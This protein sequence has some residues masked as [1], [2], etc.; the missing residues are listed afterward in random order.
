VKPRVTTGSTRRPRSWTREE[1]EAE[2]EA[3][4]GE[5]EAAEGEEEEEEEEEEAEGEEAE[6]EEAE[7]RRG[8]GG[9]ERRRETV[10]AAEPLLPLRPPQPFP[11][12]LV[13]PPAGPCHVAGGHVLRDGAPGALAG[14]GR[15]HPCS[16]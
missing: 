8:G 4:E 7:G 12:P 3:A 13:L 10:P 9:E 1:E 14:A 2:E 16:P 5:E 6:E 15:V 11:C